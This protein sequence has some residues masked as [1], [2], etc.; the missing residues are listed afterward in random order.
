MEQTIKKLIK[1]Q[2]TPFYLFDEK[3]FVEN[4]KKLEGT[5]QKVYPNYHICYSYKTN[6]TPFVCQLVKSLGGLAEVVSD[7]EYTLAKKIGYLNSQI[8]YNGPSK[9]ELLYEHLLSGGIVNIDS[10]DE[11]NRIVAF[12][13]SHVN[14]QFTIGIRINMDLGGNFISRFGLVPDSEELAETVKIIEAQQSSINW[15]SLP[16]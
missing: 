7:M 9:G 2:G 1:Q 5:F 14:K 10:L 4:Y 8:V 13:K 16:H 3:G 15:P 6:Y 12:C 11:A